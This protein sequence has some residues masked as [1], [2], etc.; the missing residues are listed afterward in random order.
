MPHFGR[1]KAYSWLAG[2]EELVEGEKTFASK[3]L[4]FFSPPGRTA[5]F[6]SFVFSLR[7]CLGWLTYLKRQNN[8]K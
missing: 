7:V 5:Y 2:N 6:F 4:F 8:H 3:F 1:R